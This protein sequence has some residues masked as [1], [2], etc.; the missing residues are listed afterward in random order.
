MTDPQ[1]TSPNEQDVAV[2]QCDREAARDLYL[3]YTQSSDEADSFLCGGKDNTT[4]I[5]SFA[6]HRITTTATLTAELA[7]A[8]AEIARLREALAALGQ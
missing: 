3:F 4:I 2:E 8:K 5:Q 6:H 1:A 7:A